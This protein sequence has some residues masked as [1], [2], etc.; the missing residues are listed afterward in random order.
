[1][2]PRRTSSSTR[3]PARQLDALFVVVSLVA[4]GS[5]WLDLDVVAVGLALSLAASAAVVDL[6]TARIPDRLVVTSLAPV[7]A[8]LVF[9]AATGRAGSAIAGVAVGMLLL[10]GP[11]VV[12][13][14]LAPAAMGFGDVKLAASLGGVLGLIEPRA[15]VLA[16]CVASGLTGVVGLVVGRRTLPFGPG[17]VVG[18]VVTLFVVWYTGGASLRWR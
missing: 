2:S 3:S 1:M 7:V 4:I 16:L 5:V 14:L 17:L 12:I 18:A 13:H 6:R 9:A 15:A 11:L 8:V 10:A